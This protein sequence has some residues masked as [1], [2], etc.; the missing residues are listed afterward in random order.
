MEEKCPTCGMAIED[1]KCIGCWM[2]ADQC[3]CEKA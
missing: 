2:A 3:T 1:G